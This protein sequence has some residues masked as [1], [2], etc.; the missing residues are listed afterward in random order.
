MPLRIGFACRKVPTR[1][2]WPAISRIRLAPGAERWPVDACRPAARTAFD[3]RCS[4]SLR[5]RPAGRGVWRS[6]IF[7]PRFNLM[8]VPATG[9]DRCPDDQATTRRAR[10]NAAAVPRSAAASPRAVSRPVLTGSLPNRMDR[11]SSTF[12]RPLSQGAGQHRASPSGQGVDPAAWW[13]E[14][15][16]K[17][18]SYETETRGARPVPAVSRPCLAG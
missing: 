11:A 14:R 6:I 8:V 7:L 18:G 15:G 12:A 13:P 4:E 2:G 1:R 3:R 5:S 17:A 9:R 16:R 10:R